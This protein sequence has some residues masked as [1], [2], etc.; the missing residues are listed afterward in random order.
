MS[1]FHT[2]VD[3]TELVSLVFGRQKGRRNAA[4]YKE[5]GLQQPGTS[6]VIWDWEWTFHPLAPLSFPSPYPITIASLKIT[7]SW[8]MVLKCPLCALSVLMPGN[9]L[10]RMRMATGSKR[11]M[12][13]KGEIICITPGM[14]P[15]SRNDTALFSHFW[16]ALTAVA[17][18][19]WKPREIWA[20]LVLL[21]HI[22]DRTKRFCT[23]R[24]ITSTLCLPNFL[25]LNCLVS[26]NSSLI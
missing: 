1:I 3:P 5:N 26:R 18:C 6:C 22:A 8:K 15:F 17:L 7:Y 20:I 25:D 4:V 23:P 13:C 10:S 24:N 14:T 2:T 11:S 9:L 12:I 21:F 16:T 19:L